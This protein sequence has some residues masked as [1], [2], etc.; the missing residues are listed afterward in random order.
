MSFLQRTGIYQ[1]TDH[2]HPAFRP[3]VPVI[4]RSRRAR[5]FAST[6][7]NANS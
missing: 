6:G 5:P 1:K 7:V 4:T 2:W 3:S